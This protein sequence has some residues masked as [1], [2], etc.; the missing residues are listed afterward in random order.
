MNLDQAVR[1]LTKTSSKQAV[2][3]IINRLP[4]RLVPDSDKI[5][6]YLQGEF[7]QQFHGRLSSIQVFELSSE[8]QVNL[9]T[10][11]PSDSFI[12]TVLRGAQAIRRKDLDRYH[13]ISRKALRIAMASMNQDDDEELRKILLVISTCL[14][15]TSPSPRDS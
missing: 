2:Y 9:A 12:D 10:K 5:T 13:P 1:M 15:Y 8:T 4:A 7:W 3:K 14:L 6:N 11:F